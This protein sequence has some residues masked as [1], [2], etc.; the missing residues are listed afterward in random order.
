MS[1]LLVIFIGFILAF[2]Y[3][4][5]NVGRRPKDLPPGPPTL[6]IIGNLHLL[7]S[8]QPH[9]QFKKW[10]DEYGPVYSLILGTSV[11]IVL[12][13]DVAIKDLLDKRSNI[14]S[15]RPPLYIG[16]IVS[17]GWRM[18]LMEYGDTWRMIRRT[19]HNHLNIRAAKSFVPYQ[20]L[21]N[22]QLLLGFLEHPERWDSHLRRYTNSLTTQ[23]VFGFRTTNINDARMHQLFDGFAEFAEILESVPAR[24]V[25]VFPWL[26][27]LPEALLPVKRRAR[28]LHVKE[29][30]LYLSHWL[31]IKDKVLREV[32]NPCICLDLVKSQKEEGFSDGLASY[33]SGSLLEAG[34]DTTYSILI[35]FVQAMILFP[36]VARTAQ[37]ELDQVCANRLPTLDDERDM[38]YIRGCVKETMRWMPTAIVGVPHACIRDDEYMGWR[39]P[40]G[41]GM[42]WNVWGIHYDEQKFSRPEIFDPLRY[43]DDFQ[44]AAEAT[45]NSDSTKRDHFIFGAGRR[46]CQGMHIADRS[47]F[48]AVSRLL[49]AF[50]FQA[51]IDVYGNKVL[52]NPSQ[53]TDGFI[54]KPKEFDAKIVPRSEKKAEMVREEWAKVTDKLDEEGQWKHIPEELLLKM[55]L[56]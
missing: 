28:K 36:E 2:L 20:D 14:Y 40:K 4:I 11:M 45:L 3:S 25:D 50:D 35:G 30:E 38:Q 54:V 12:T 42:M 8:T 46:V 52:P 39:I 55:R 24:M 13:S 7:P 29:S 34:S 18:L 5:R 1:T 21:E 15:S 19:V 6:P 33:I 51:P 10:A 22:R 17:G 26:R 49:W 9:H 27:F 43:A 41:A 31:T 37:A 44:S 53:L 23:M 16:Q 48:L 32:A 56:S 47:L